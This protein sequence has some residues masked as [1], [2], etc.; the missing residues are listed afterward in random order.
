MGVGTSNLWV[1]ALD[2]ADEKTAITSVR[3]SSGLGPSDH[4]PFYLD[5]I[6]VLAFFTGQ[7][8]D[9]HKPSDDPQLVDFKGIIQITDYILE[10]IKYIDEKPSVPFLTTR[11]KPQREAAR[12]KVS[13]GVMPDYVHAGKGMR[14]DGVTTGRPAEKAGIK[15]GDVVIKIGELEVGDIYDYMEGLSRYSKGEEAV[16]RVKRGVE[17]LEFIV[18][19]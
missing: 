12:F 18:T 11:Q 19:F 14:I 8:D 3:D 6:P 17:E 10:I 1:A 2:K 13:L 7:H 5:S 4:A 16:V 15:A 9:Y